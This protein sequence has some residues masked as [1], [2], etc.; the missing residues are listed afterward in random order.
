ML[1]VA[2]VLV[3]VVA[4]RLV[5]DDVCVEKGLEDVD[6]RVEGLV[7]AGFV[8]GCV[9]VLLVTGRVEVDGLVVCR[10]DGDVLTA[11]LVVRFEP[12]FCLDEL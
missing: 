12:T 1:L 2:G 5:G 7:D 4:V 3:V 9:L 11:L 8:A 10:P 6:G